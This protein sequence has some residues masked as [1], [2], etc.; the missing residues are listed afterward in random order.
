MSPLESVHA[1]LHAALTDALATTDGGGPVPVAVNVA[2]TRALPYVVLSSETQA[3]SPVFRDADGRPADVTK[4]L[5]V[6]AGSETAARAL[7]G[8][9]AAAL[10]DV[11]DLQARITATGAALAAMGDVFVGT[12]PDHAPVGDDPLGSYVVRARY[13]LDT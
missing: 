11:P 9:C 4:T 2:P 1:A 12:G 6:Y 10:A 3:E 13:T 5:R 7:A 8:L